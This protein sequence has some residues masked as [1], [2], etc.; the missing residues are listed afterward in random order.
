MLL[1]RT[2]YETVCAE[3]RLKDERGA[4]RALLLAMGEKG[5]FPGWT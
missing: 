4:L 3:A 5:R 2:L 1:P